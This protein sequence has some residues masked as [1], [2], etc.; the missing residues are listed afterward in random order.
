MSGDEEARFF[1][2]RQVSLSLSLLSPPPP[3]ASSSVR[4][5]F[6]SSSSCVPECTSVLCECPPPPHGG[7]W[8]PGSVVKWEEEEGREAAAVLPSLANL[9]FFSICFHE[10]P[11]RRNPPSPK[12]VFLLGKQIDQGRFSFRIPPPP[13][14]GSWKRQGKI[15]PSAKSRR[16]DLF[17]FCALYSPP[18]RP[19][20]PT[21]AP[22]SPA[23][24]PSG[25]SGSV[26]EKEA[27]KHMISFKKSK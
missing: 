22:S 7:R 5:H 15:F 23:R 8:R 3:S 12:L 25:G 1:F 13:F 27:V 21:L 20:P 26:G 10:P 18:P 4:L 2:V 14:D 6:S 19:S 24:R 11:S 16:G 9:S 17:F